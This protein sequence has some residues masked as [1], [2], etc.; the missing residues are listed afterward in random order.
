MMCI[1]LSNFDTVLLNVVFWGPIYI[2]REIIQKM[3]NYPT[4]F[5]MGVRTGI[6]LTLALIDAR[7]CYI[8]GGF[9]NIFC[10]RLQRY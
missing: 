10:N 6:S 3:H 4:A 8:I 9:L 2:L 5:L 7:F 1:I